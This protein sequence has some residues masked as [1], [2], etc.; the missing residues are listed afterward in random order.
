MTK[1]VKQTRV[2]ET[3]NHFKNGVSSKDQR[4]RGNCKFFTL[5]VFIILF[6]VRA[7]AQDVIILKNGDEIKSLVQEV[8]TDYVKYKKFDNQTGPVY[9]MAISEIFMIKYA[10]G[11]KDVLN[12]PAKS[13][14]TK[15]EQVIQQPIKEEAK[16]EP[17]KSPNLSVIDGKVFLNGQSIKHEQIVDILT[18]NDMVT[19]AGATDIYMKGYSKLQASKTWSLSGTIFGLGGVG[20]LIAY[21]ASP[22]SE[23]ASLYET[24]GYTFCG[25]SLICWIPANSLK[26]SGNKKIYEAINTYNTSIKSKHSS[27]VS[28]NF[29]ITRS[30]GL[31]FTL[32]F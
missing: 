17:Q 26:S 7:V 23:Y 20:F 18:S 1:I 32:N 29:G 14:Q 27:D 19:N 4:S 16:Q 15:A 28:L 25:A 10:N 13:S 11:S 8:G 31:G 21:L 3:G 2:M 12:E 5:L 6:G 22:N 24:F 9:N 30:G